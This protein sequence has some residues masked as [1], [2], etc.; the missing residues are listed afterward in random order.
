MD[1]LALRRTGKQVWPQG[2]STGG[3]GNCA[4][5]NRE[6]RPHIPKLTRLHESLFGLSSAATCVVTISATPR[7]AS[8]GCLRLH[9]QGYLRECQLRDTLSLFVDH[10]GGMT[11]KLTGLI[12][13]L[14]YSGNSPINP[15]VEFASSAR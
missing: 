6:C 9:L 7:F 5:V 12:V 1:S 4:S 2:P 13:Y 15:T 10:Q 8:S 14:L 11:L 3:R